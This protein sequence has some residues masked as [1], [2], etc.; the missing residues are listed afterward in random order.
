MPNSKIVFLLLILQN[1][2]SFTFSQ[3]VKIHEDYLRE[4]AYEFYKPSGWD[5]HLL[6]YGEPYQM[7]THSD[8]TDY[9]TFKSGQVKNIDELDLSAIQRIV[10]EGED[11]SLQE[12]IAFLEMYAQQLTSL[13]SILINVSTEELI[14]TELIN[15]LKKMEHLQIKC[16]ENQLKQIFT[17][18]ENLKILDL[19]WN[20][21]DQLPVSITKLKYLHTLI[22][23]NNQF[24]NIPVQI[25]KMES[26]V[27]LD[28]RNN[29]ISTLP[30]KLITAS[31]VKN[32][33]ICENDFKSLSRQQIEKFDRLYIDNNNWDD[34]TIDLLIKAG[35][36]V[37]AYQGNHKD[38]LKQEYRK[39]NISPISGNGNLK[40][41]FQEQQNSHHLDLV[42]PFSDIEDVDTTRKIQ[43]KN[44]DS[45]EI[46][47]YPIQYVR[48]ESH[49]LLERNIDQNLQFFQ[50]ANR[51]E[52]TLPCIKADI[53]SSYFSP[54]F[55]YVSDW[56]FGLK[57]EKETLIDNGLFKFQQLP[58]A[59]EYAEKVKNLKINYS[60][61]NDV[62]ENEK[63]SLT[64]KFNETQFNCD[65]VI[66]A[67]GESK[68][69]LFNQI[70]LKNF[71]QINHL[72]IEFETGEKN[73]DG[74]GFLNNLNVSH[75]KNIQ[76]IQIENCSK[77]EMLLVLQKFKKSGFNTFFVS[78]LQKVTS[79][80]FVKLKEVKSL[81]NLVLWEYCFDKKVRG[82]EFEKVKELLPKIHLE[83]VSD[84]P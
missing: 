81:Q 57:M 82:A 15:I 14:S 25:A 61:W 30:E 28:L 71:T 7:I 73:S 41:V 5:E 33:N 51:F 37:V 67:M 47:D 75:L 50:K 78:T 24:K 72:V 84:L 20:K 11:G 77:E 10:I 63:L 35:R 16:T 21:L 69:N 18:C 83:M 59:L 58:Y 64:K 74:I 68:L 70:S 2:F 79:E 31:K 45:N 76:S 34:A 80:D 40:M 60:F 23:N 44:M 43:I 9:S 46:K 38:V 39:M 52:I 48:S 6:K 65:T 62:P 13:E 27:R 22:L 26:L 42:L 3:Q 55:V 17:E 8:Y 49:F 56:I 12:Q 36:K 66:I 53:I 54:N 4:P 32:L 19:S 1:C 29:Q